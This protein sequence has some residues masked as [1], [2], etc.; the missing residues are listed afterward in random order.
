MTSTEYQAKVDSIVGYML[1]LLENFDLPQPSIKIARKA[2]F[3]QI[4]SH[5]MEVVD[6][7]R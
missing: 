5:F 3:K 1:V 6:E 2:L 7:K 4:D